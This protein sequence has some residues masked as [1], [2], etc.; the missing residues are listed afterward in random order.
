MLKTYAAP[1]WC[2]PVDTINT[3]DVFSILAPLW[4]DK[5][6]TASLL[7][8]HIERVLDAAKVAR[9]RMMRIRRDGEAI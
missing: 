1:L 4:K 8:R 3:N 2:L 6:E 5:P 7:R 9:L